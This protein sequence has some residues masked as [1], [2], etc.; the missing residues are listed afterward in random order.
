MCIHQPMVA[1]EIRH[2]AHACAIWLK[3]LRD[4]HKYKQ[5]DNTLV[6]SISDLTLPHTKYP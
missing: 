6:S 3:L 1:L 2:K 5:Q 4:G